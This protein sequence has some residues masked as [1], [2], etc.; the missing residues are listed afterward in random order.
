MNNLKKIGFTA[1]AGSLAVFSVSNADITLGGSSELTYTTDNG[2][3]ISEIT[4][5]PYGMSH[6]ITFTG[7]GELSNGIGYTVYS[8]MAGQDMVADSSY[9]QFDAGDFGKFG[10][11]QG[12]GQYG[13][14]TIALSIPTAYEEADHATGVLADGL[15]VTGDMNVLGYINTIM[16]VSINLEYNPTTGGAV[17][18][19]AGANSGEGAGMKNANVALKYS[20]PGVDGLEVRAGYSQNRVHGTTGSDKTSGV[21]GDG[22][23]EMTAAAVYAW[24]PLKAGYQRSEIQSS[25]A[26]V[27]GESVEA[28]GVAFN[29]NDSLS[30]SYGINDNTL[31]V[32]SG[33]DVTEESVGYMA[34]YTMGSASVRL[35]INETD[36]VN[37]VVNQ[38]DE[39]M[40]ISL[41][42][43][44]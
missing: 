34:A 11:D 40:E 24:G 17:A 37:G 14:G 12:V 33:T 41:K 22:D 9:M 26:A 42:L 39:N 35:A 25:G 44:F 4:G 5:N 31:D 32:P 2:G 6:T 29:V 7:T 10:I 36:N 3:N 38:T 13:I 18:S 27:G 21:N 28:M 8:E 23:E 15:D 1:L 43:S 20:I 16:G 19:Q 30:I